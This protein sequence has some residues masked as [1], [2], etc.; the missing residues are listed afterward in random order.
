MSKD[1]NTVGTAFSDALTESIRGAATD[2]GAKVEA[3]EGEKAARVAEGN[4]QGKKGCKMPRI[5]MALLPD[6]YQMLKM[7]SAAT[8][9]TITD[10]NNQILTSYVND[11][12]DILARAKALT[13]DMKNLI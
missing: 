10:I 12:P 9:K 2:K 4:T 6:N 13:D 11:H 5:N 8:G 1:F 7:L 3:T